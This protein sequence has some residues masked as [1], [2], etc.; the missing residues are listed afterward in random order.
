[1]YPFSLGVA[2]GDPA[3]DSVVI[4]TRLAPLPL[5]GGGMGNAPE[6]AGWEIA[7]DDQFRAIVQSGP[8][9]ATPE[10][11]HSI[12]VDVEGLAPAHEY[13]YR[14]TTGEWISPTGRTRTAPA[15]GQPLSR[16]RFGFASCANWEHGY[17]SAYRDLAR[18]EID[19]TIFLGDYLYE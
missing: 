19:L 3:P 5:V 17:F 10:L 12:H 16:L 6:T 18:Q 9:T 8:A 13:Y 1:M 14:F 7:L 2:S 4:W 11:A 15:V